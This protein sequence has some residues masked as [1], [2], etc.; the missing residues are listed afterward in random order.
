[1]LNQLRVRATDS[2]DKVFLDQPPRNE[3][4]SATMLRNECFSFQLAYTAEEG[5]LP[6]AARICLK[7]ESD[8]APWISI[9]QVGHIASTL[10]TYPRVD[11]DYERSAPGLYPDRLDR[12]RDPFEVKLLLNRW[13]SLWIQVENPAGLPP[14]RHTIAFS[15]LSGQDETLQLARTEVSLTVLDAT[16]PDQSLIYTNWFHADCLASIYRC[17]ALSE[18]HWRIMGDF[19]EVAARF[20]INMML[21]PCF[22]PPLDTAVGAERMTVQLVTVHKLQDRY[23]FDFSQLDRWIRLCQDKG[24]RYFEHSHLFTQ[25]GAYHAPKIMAVENNEEKQ[26]FGWDTDA[27]GPDY[28]EFLHQY[29]TALRTHLQELQ[30]YDRFYF[31][32]SDEPVEKHQDSYARARQIFRDILPEKNVFDALSHVAFYDKGLVDIPVPVTCTIEDFRGKVP[33]LWTYYTGFQS[34]MYS[35]R[36]ISM[37]SRRN[38]ILGTQLF[39][40]DVKGFLQ[41]AFNFYYTT[42]SREVCN[43]YQSSDAFGEFPSGTAYMV[44]PGP[45]GPVLSIRLFT[46][47]D[48]LQDMRAMQLLSSLI[49]REETMAL[50][51]AHIGTVD[52]THAPHSDAVLLGLREAINR[53]IAACLEKE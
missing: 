33:E 31:H 27:S 49:G 6:N 17:D 34:F 52:F 10:P 32:I 11:D 19:I 2:L 8:L 47:N 14:G 48:G 21:T 9:Y 35:N 3:F 28:T 20:G 12:L 15:W 29:L 7:V 39:A 5:W 30:V 38:R 4:A 25:W 40:Y 37:A 18:E 45:D 23:A 26:I 42:L 36:L 43:P 51:Q 13:Q 44:Y 1:M 22:T 53:K 50:I 16:L 41:W 24:I 46:F